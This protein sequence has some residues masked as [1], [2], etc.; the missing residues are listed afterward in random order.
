MI[1]TI[2]LA[3]LKGTLFEKSSNLNRILSTI[4]E[5]RHKNVDYILFPELFLT[6]HFI[7]ERLKELAEPLDGESIQRIQEKVKET[8][9]G[10][11]V[12]FPEIKK[13]RYYNSAAMIGKDGSIKGIYRK[14]H[15]F[16]YE[17]AYFTPGQEIPI[18]E[19]E[20]GDV[21][22]LMTFDLEFPEM[23]RIYALKGAKLIMVLNAH[24]VPYEPHQEIF[25][26][27][28]AL[29]NQLYIAA[30]NK[31]GLEKSSLFFGKSAVISPEG[32]IVAQCGNNEEVIIVSLELSKV[33]QIRTEQ[34][35]KYLEMRKGKI[36][37]T[38][39]LV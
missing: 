2:A 27:S 32:H 23:A 22:I 13:N 30:T 10:V 37:K 35:M 11:I 24:N 20:A 7:Q 36:Y 15:L 5:C 39:G 8:G 14:V 18:F 9:V 28:R 25:L 19:T 38:N 4:E 17:Q 16:D 21:A 1:L 31:V 6:G 26:K 29:E 3:Q 33:N 34:P 12:G